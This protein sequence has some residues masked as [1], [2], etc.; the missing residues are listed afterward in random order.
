MLRRMRRPYTTAMYRRL[1]ERLRREIPDLGLGTDVIAGFPGESEADSTATEELAGALAFSYLHV[2]PYS[3]RQGTEA[4]ALD[5]HVESA[6]VADRARRL[7]TLDRG[8]RREFRLSMLNTARDVLVLG[9]RDRET[10]LLTGLTGNYVEVLFDGAD[11]LAGGMT[12]LRLSRLHGDR[13]FGV[14]EDAR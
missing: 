5:G 8:R 1:V 11:S 7:R 4:A 9:T 13:V 14:Q 6:V 2:F 10:G 3:D 12:T